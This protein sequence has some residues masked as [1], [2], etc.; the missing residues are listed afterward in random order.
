LRRIQGQVEAF[1]AVFEGMFGDFAFGG[2]KEGAQQVRLAFEFD[3]LCAED[4][5]VD[6]PV[7]GAKLHL[8]AGQLAFGL[9]RLDQLRPLFG[10]HPKTQFQG[11]ATNCILYGPAEQAFEVLVG[12]GDQAVFLAGQQHHVRAQVKQCREALFRA[13][14]C[15]FTLALVGD[16]ADHA[17]H[18]RTAVFVR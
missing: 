14:Q 8:H 12:F 2:V 6:L 18:A 15:L 1:L 5:V 7:A 3:F 17:N 9:G 4:A 16:L 13:A 10:I 11:G